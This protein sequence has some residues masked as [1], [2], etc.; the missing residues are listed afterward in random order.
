M[1][2]FGWCISGCCVT[3][4]LIKEEHTTYIMFKLL[5]LYLVLIGLHAMLF[6]GGSSKD[7]FNHMVATWILCNWLVI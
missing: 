3:W 1:G 4:A 6:L 2:F 7:N 5:A